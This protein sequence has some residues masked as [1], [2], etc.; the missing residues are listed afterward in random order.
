MSYV[1]DCL[2]DTINPVDLF[3]SI[4]THSVEGTEWAMP[5]KAIIVH[6]A[7]GRVRLRVPQKRFDETF[8]QEVLRRLSACETVLQ[9][10]VNP[11]SA[12]VLIL[13]KDPVGVLLQ[14]ASA[15][16]VTDLVDI[17]FP[18]PPRP[19]AARLAD[20][21]KNVDAAIVRGT[22]GGVDGSAIVVTLLLAAAGV[23]LARGRVFGA[24]PMLWYAGQAIGGLIPIASPPARSSFLDV[25]APAEPS[26]T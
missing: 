22:H 14:Q 16:G 20:R 3:V 25:S 23:E 8:F 11:R 13:Y 12:S 5:P 15:S 26:A 9:T 7:K 2:L 24:I 10:Q 4:V 19:L 6:H 18:S 21:L 17:K 1:W